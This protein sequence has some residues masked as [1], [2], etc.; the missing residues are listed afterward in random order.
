MKLCAAQAVS[1]LYA[2]RLYKGLPCFDGE[3]SG[4][5][6]VGCFLVDP[7]ARQRGVAEKLL[8]GGITLARAAG[9]RAI[10]AFPRRAELVSAGELWTGPYAAFVRAG[11][12]EVHSFAPYPV[13]RRDLSGDA[14]ER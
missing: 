1:K 12:Q 10:E 8:E 2:Q 14:A 4:V 11:F 6:A 3:R 5:L 7:G 9:A 13:L